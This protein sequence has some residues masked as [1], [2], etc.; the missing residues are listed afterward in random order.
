MLIPILIA[1]AVILFVLVVM[2]IIYIRVTIS[3]YTDNDYYKQALETSDPDAATKD[4]INGMNLYSLQ[5]IPS[6][7]SSLNRD[8]IQQYVH[9]NAPLPKLSLPIL[10]SGAIHSMTYYPKAFS[11]IVLQ[12]TAAAEKLHTDILTGAVTYLTFAGITCPVTAS[13]KLQDAIKSYAS[14]NDL[15][16]KSALVD[17][18]VIIAVHPP[19]Y[20]ELIPGGYTY[21]TEATYDLISFTG[22]TLTDSLQD[23]I[24]RI[25]NTTI[26]HALGYRI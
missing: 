25:S 18:I 5:F 13:D 26:T 3:K 17:K 24:S 2:Q 14:T 1:V 7:I 10:Y 6:V 22:S 11:F 9:E 8:S 21:D 15:D 4:R 20:D 23:L 12:R 16:L 19:K